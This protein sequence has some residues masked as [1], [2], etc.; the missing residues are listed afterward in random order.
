MKAQV[1][2]DFLVECTLSDDNPEETLTEQP[3]KSS[4]MGST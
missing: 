2:V 4:D 3:P 1:L